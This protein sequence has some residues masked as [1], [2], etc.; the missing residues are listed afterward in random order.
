M[1]R[2]YQKVLGIGLKLLLAAFIMVSCVPQ[3]KIKYFQSAE[4]QAKLAIFEAPGGEGYRVNK[5]D[6]LYIKVQSIDEKTYK[7][8]N[9]EGS[10][11]YASQAYNEAGMYLTSYA[12]SDSGTIEFPFVGTVFVEGLTLEEIKTRIQKVVS[13]YLLETTVIVKLVNFKITILGEVK[14]P[15]H[16]VIYQDKINIF[17]AIGRAND[18]TVF[19]NKNAVIL[20]R[21]SEKGSEIHEIDLTKR[22]IL[23]SEF[24]YLQPNDIIYIEP[25][26]GKQFAFADFPYALI[27]SSITTTLLI[28]SYFK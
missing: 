19:G 25:L 22:D 10:Q 28:L 12:V 6:N 8:F 15:G 23:A 3:R 24:F 16:Y 1:L 26:R 13:Q 14:N 7:F 5:G 27:F 18:L 21:Q 2:K 17:E 11:N 4:G 20:V 9:A